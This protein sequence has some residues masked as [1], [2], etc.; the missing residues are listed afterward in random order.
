MTESNADWLRR[1]GPQV[2][3]DVEEMHREIAREEAR[4]LAEIRNALDV[5]TNDLSTVT[6]EEVWKAS[7]ELTTRVTCELWGKKMGWD[8]P[9][10]NTPAWTEMRNAWLDGSDEDE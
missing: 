7:H 9:A 5:T 6:L 2:A 4:R 10:Y 8:I 1:I 3:R